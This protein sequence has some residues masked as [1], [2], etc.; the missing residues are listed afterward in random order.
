M[1]VCTYMYIYHIYIFN[2]IYIRHR[3][4]V[5]RRTEEQEDRRRYAAHV[6]ATLTQVRFGAIVAERL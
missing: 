1:Y 5:G 4:E 3:R 2:I 6:A